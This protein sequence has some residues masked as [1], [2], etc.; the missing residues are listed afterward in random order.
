MAAVVVIITAVAVVVVVRLP[1]P[2]PC[3]ESLAHPLLLRFQRWLRLQ[4]Y[5]YQYQSSR[6]QH[7]SSSSSSSS[8]LRRILSTCSSI[9]YF[10]IIM[11]F[12]K[13]LLRVIFFSSSHRV[14][15]CVATDWNALVTCPLG[16]SDF[17]I[18]TFM[19]LILSS[20]LV[21]VFMGIG[22]YTSGLISFKTN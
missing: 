19:L 15:R 7:H 18:Q 6:H 14:R 21:Q 13:A 1:N 17:Y 9:I 5:Q 11:I 12:Y 2:S 8:R 3:P 4:Q 20:V 16:G 22:L 10:S